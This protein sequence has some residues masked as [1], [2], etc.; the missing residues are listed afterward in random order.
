MGENVA[1][2]VKLP[3][4][5][6]YRGKQSDFVIAM[7]MR[8]RFFSFTS[9]LSLWLSIP[10]VVG[11]IVFIAQVRGFRSLSWPL[12]VCLLPNSSPFT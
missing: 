7:L 2:C 3:I 11:F 9:T 6:A 10:A 12:P 5:L 4:C 1:W 8:V